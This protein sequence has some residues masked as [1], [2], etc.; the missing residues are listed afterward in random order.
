MGNSQALW[1]SLRF[2]PTAG[3][4]LKP[5]HQH[6]TSSL[7][8]AAHCKAAL[9]WPWLSFLLRHFLL[10]FLT[11]TVL[12]LRFICENKE[13]VTGAAHRADVYLH[14]WASSRAPR[15]KQTTGP[16]W[17]SN[18][19]GALHRTRG[20]FPHGAAADRCL[21]VSHS[22]TPRPLKESPHGAALTAVLHA[23]RY[24]QTAPQEYW[25][26]HTNLLWC[27]NSK[28]SYYSKYPIQP[29]K[30]GHL[31]QLGIHWDSGRETILL[32]F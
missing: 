27:Q 12:I 32:D 28:V 13:K 14:R 30:C 7:Q 8:Q 26:I 29:I 20:G 1:S 16:L 31:G 23:L 25:W 10:F 11:P 2:I 22:S 19:Y 3:S 15:Q 5:W 21:T 9:S 4:L 18:L 24:T 6:K 17:N